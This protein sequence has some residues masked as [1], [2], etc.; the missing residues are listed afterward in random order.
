MV[1][2]EHVINNLEPVIHDYG[3]AVVAVVLTFESFG[4]PLPGKVHC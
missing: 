4:V 2:I 1:D 3:V